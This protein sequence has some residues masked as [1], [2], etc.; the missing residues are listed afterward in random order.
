MRAAGS[1]WDCGHQQ[2]GRAWQGTRKAEHQC[3]GTAPAWQTTTMEMLTALKS[4]S[5]GLLPDNPFCFFQT[6]R[7]FK[8]QRI[9][10]EGTLD[11]SPFVLPL[12]HSI[13][14]VFHS[15]TTESN[16]VLPLFHGITT[17][18][19]GS[20]SCRCSLSVAPSLLSLMD[21]NL[22]KLCKPYGA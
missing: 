12:F 19:N 6:V 22:A 9:A 21:G 8:W 4:V 2:N 18:P 7:A 11:P 3:R 5:Q 10:V 16:F 20:F 1:Q 17:E 13:T 14:T 15:I